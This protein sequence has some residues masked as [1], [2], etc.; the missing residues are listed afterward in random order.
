[1]RKAFTLAEIL[2]TITIVGVVS[3]IIISFIPNIQKKIRAEK[4]SYSEI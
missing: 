2:V 4:N 3:L 1:M